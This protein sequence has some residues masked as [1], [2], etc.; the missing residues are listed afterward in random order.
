MINGSIGDMSQSFALRN[1]NAALKTDMQ[2]LALEL[3]SGQVADSRSVLG[4]NMSY[5]SEIERSLTTLEGYNLATTEATHYAKGAQ[6]AL[7]R[8]QELGQELSSSLLLAS[9]SAVGLNTADLALNARSALQSMVS[10]LNTQV[11]GRALF[12]GIATDQVP[13]DGIDP[14]L[15]A[16]R[17]VIAAEATPEDMMTAAADWFDDPAGFTATVYQ[18]SDTA[19][20]AFKLSDTEQ[21]SLDV[22]AT[23]PAVKAMLLTTAVS[24]LATDPALGLSHD[25]QVSLFNA[26]SIRMISANNDLISLQ[27]RVGFAE[28]GIDRISTRNASERSSLEFAKGDLLGIDP[29]ETATRL[30]EVQFQLQSLYSV[31]VR[32]SQLSLVNFL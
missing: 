10:G 30:E 31:T 22:R 18:G 28:A 19:L 29:Y 15:D 2:R 21:L 25:D 9:N 7:G 5:L 16:L 1:R 24:T 13:F 8:V 14:L 3:S 23:D 20:A 27:G 17:T 4:G 32:M 26:A 6:A 12:S 11:A